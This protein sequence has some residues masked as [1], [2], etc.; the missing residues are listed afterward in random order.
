V[1]CT[2]CHVDVIQGKGE[3]PKEMCLTCHGEREKLGKYDDHRLIHD[4]HVTEH[5]VE[6]FQC[7]IE[8]KHK[9]TTLHDFV[10]R[11]CSSCHMEKHSAQEKLYMGTGG[12][13]VKEMPS[14]MFLARVDC[15]GCHILP[16]DKGEKMFFTGQTIKATEAA[17]LN[18]HG[19]EY[20]GVLD[21][22]RN[23]VNQYINNLKPLLVSVK[24]VIDSSSNG[25]QKEEALKLY[26]DALYNYNF[27]YYGKGVHNIEYATELLAK[28]EENLNKAKELLGK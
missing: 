12:K 22:W 28:S 20:K 27:V 8:I 10:K 24:A 5:K 11:D 7:H 14:P 19:I 15:S 6:C 9:V 23:T 25:K 1:E 13:G 2:K 16:R 17:C 26:N 4:K 3:V 21:D 18:C